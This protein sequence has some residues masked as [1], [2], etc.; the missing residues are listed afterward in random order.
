MQL[1][2][3]ALA[4]RRFHRIFNLPHP[5]SFS[6]LSRV[7]SLLIC[8]IKRTQSTNTIIYTVALLERTKRMKKLRPIKLHIPE[9]L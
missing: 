4:R 6:S 1:I 8:G 5:F 3:N 9:E 7:E 2:Y